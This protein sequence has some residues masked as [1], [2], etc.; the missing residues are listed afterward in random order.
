MRQLRTTITP[1][2]IVTLLL[3][4]F[5]LARTRAW[6][7]LEASTRGPAGAAASFGGR[8][9]GL[10]QLARLPVGTTLELA[11]HD[12][13]PA[14]GAAAV[15]DLAITVGVDSEA[16]FAAAFA[17]AREEAAAW[18]E[19]FLVVT[20]GERTST[21]VFADTAQEP[22][23][24]GPR[25]DAAWLPAAV[26]MSEGDSIAVTLYAGDPDS[27]GSV[28]E[29]LTFVYGVDSEI[30]FRSALRAA[31]VDADAAVVVISPRSVTLDLGVMRE[32]MA[33]GRGRLDARGAAAGPFGRLDAPRRMLPGRAR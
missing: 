3:G 17:A 5:G 7:G 27:G 28:L 22:S 19:A 9:A 4:G 11:F 31:A 29:A 1:I 30:G 15:I 20:I 13:D 14:E 23:T 12:G 16:A 24:R 2:L 33:D 25:R 18:D 32:R 8:M 26:G 10:P 21:V 6:G